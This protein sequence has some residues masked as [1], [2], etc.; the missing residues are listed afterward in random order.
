[1][2]ELLN[3]FASLRKDL[4]RLRGDQEARPH[5]SVVIPVNAQK[6]LTNIYRLLSD[7]V[8]YSGG[9]RIEIALVINNYPADAP[10][11]EIDT[12]RQIGLE[13]LGIPRVEHEGGVAIAARI[14]GIRA[15]RSAIVILFDADCRIPDPT[16]LINWYIARFDDGCDLAYTHVAYTDLS[17]DLSVKARMWVH[18]TSRWLRRNILGT[19][20]SRG[21]NYA[22]RRQLIL[23]LFAQG[24]IPYDIHVGPVVKSMRGRIAYSGAKELVVLTSGRF[25]TPGWKVLVEYLIWRTGYYR[26]ILKMKPKK[27]VTDQS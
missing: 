2:F 6:D 24:R 3:D 12:Y 13:V 25:F 16:A 17:A 20:T 9:K 1:M 10:P 26:R 4:I 7:L 27:T 15:A 5:A 18:H 22:I 19:P 8:R 23:D 21:S 14:P 11:A